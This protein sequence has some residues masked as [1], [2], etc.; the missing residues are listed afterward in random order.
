M[1]HMYCFY[2]ILF[3]NLF[4]KLGVVKI[5]LKPNFDTPHILIELGNAA[6]EWASE[7]GI[8]NNGI[9]KVMQILNTWPLNVSFIDLS[10]H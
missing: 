4:F 2:Y 10:H 7:I 5:I 9:K 8:R 6:M 3:C 1:D